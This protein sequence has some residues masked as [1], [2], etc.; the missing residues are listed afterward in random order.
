M[1]SRAD[2]SGPTLEDAIAL[3]VEAHRG[4]TDRNGEPEILHVLRVLLAMRTDEQ[5]VAAVL[6]DVIEDSALTLEDLR[7]RGYPPRV[8]AAVDAMTA[9]EGESYEDRVARAAA[10][11]IA[12][13]IKKAD[14]ADKMDLRR[15]R[16]VR[17]ADAERF[18]RYQRA[19]WRLTGE[20][21]PEQG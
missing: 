16:E 2:E 5:R 11:E 21:P 20:S 6:H 17:E 14:L 9:R 15:V 7:G 4:H 18:A 3:A 13:E 12:R 1:T 8:V 19:W 10:D